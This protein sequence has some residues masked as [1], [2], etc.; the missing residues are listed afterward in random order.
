LVFWQN[1]WMLLP[2]LLL[3]WATAEAGVRGP[4]SE[5]LARAQAGDAEAQTDLGFHY[6]ENAKP[7]D[8]EKARGWLQKA[9]D[10]GDAR[11]ERQIGRL[12][13][14]LDRAHRVTTT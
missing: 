7:L 4:G 13:D 14:R 2:V 11:A 5:R 3:A 9:A 10:Q 6:S 8:F 12:Y 1:L